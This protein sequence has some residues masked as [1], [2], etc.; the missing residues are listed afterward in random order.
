MCLSILH[1]DLR[2]KYTRDDLDALAEEEKQAWLEV[3]EDEREEKSAGSVV[4]EGVV[5]VETK[6]PDEEGGG[7]GGVEDGTTA[8]GSAAA[9]LSSGGKDLSITAPEG[10]RSRRRFVDGGGGVLEGF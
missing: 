6:A 8:A 7:G 10:E 3:L 4:E 5:A 9:L 2:N 1:Q